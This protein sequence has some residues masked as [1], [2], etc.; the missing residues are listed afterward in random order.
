MSGVRFVV[1][2]KLYPL[3]KSQRVLLAENGLSL[4]QCVTERQTKT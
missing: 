3:G 1:T 2:T 4:V